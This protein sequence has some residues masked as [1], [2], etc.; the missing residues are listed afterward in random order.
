M[1]AAAPISPATGDL[2]EREAQLYMRTFVRIPVALARGEGVRVWDVEDNEY[3]DFFGGI[4]VNVLGHCHPAVVDAVTEQAKTLIHTTCLYYTEPQLELGQLLVEN[5]CL[6]R[7]FYVNSGAEATETAIKLARKWGKSHRDGAYRII[8][9]EGS[10]HGRTFG[11][12]AATG[13]P[14]YHHD[15][16][17]L[18]AG[19]SHVPFNDLDALKSA[20]NDETV[21]IMLEPVMGEAGV[22]PATAEYLQGA[23][24]LCDDRGILLILD[25]IQSGMGR[26]GRLWAYETYGVEPDVMPLAKGLAGG[27]PIGVCLATEAAAAFEPGDHGST[28]GGNLVACAAGVA[29][30][31]TIIE[32]D[33]P[34]NVRRVGDVLGERLAA[35]SEETGAIEEIRQ[36]GLLVGIEL[37]QPVAGDVLTKCMERG[38]L[39]NKTSDTTVRLA[40]PLII[41]EEHVDQAC[42]VLGTA[43][44]AAT[45]AD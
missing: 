9:A 33:I 28:F 38:L 34:A 5:S 7:V 8:T 30:L 22:Y 16:A 29:T 44:K 26:S 14:H 10:F 36:S 31:R 21:A 35:L 45:A 18:P 43:I 37:H 17:P 3:L 42:A 1:A 20:V 6:D 13:Q 23:R 12:L 40:P 24:Q 11:A 2:A 19:F 41:S 15:F 27:M 39:V 25:E 32:E 4:A